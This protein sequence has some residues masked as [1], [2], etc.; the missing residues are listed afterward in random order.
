MPRNGAPAA[1]NTNDYTLIISAMNS[2]STVESGT[3][4]VTVT[5]VNEAPV[6][7]AITPPTTFVEYTAGTFDITA[8]DEDSGDMLA[9]TLNAPNHGAT[10]SSTGTFTWTPG[11]DDG[12]MARTFSVTGTDDGGTPPMMASA[13]FDITAVERPNQAPTGATITGATT[14]VAPATVTLEATAMDADTGTTLTYAWVVTT[15]DGGTIAPTTGDSTTY[16]PPALTAGD[17]A[18]D[19]VI[20]LTVSD[21]TAMATDTHTVTVNPPVAAGTARPSPTWRCSQRPFWC[22]KTPPQSATPISSSQSAP[23]P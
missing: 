22:L 5:D 15:A 23:A 7:A 19:I 13:T 14:L 6:L 2:V 20:T 8:T 12:G 16:T 17:A 3:I 11:E 4:T 1:D 21:G 18:R 9:Y 10:L